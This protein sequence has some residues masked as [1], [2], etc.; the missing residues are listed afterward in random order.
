MNLLKDVIIEGTI[1]SYHS[2]KSIAIIVIPLMIFMEVA[3]EL[4]WLDVIGKLFAPITRLFSTKEG[5]V[6]PLTVGLIFGI[7]YGA[8]VLIKVGE[9]GLLDKR[10]M[11]IVAFFLAACHAVIEDTLL[12]V[13]IGSIGWI[14]LVFRILAAVLTTLLVSKWSNLERML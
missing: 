9:D 6:L 8:G 7:S 5:A 10:S 3:K 11:F 13:A 1:G 14:I 4:K 12:F 2:I